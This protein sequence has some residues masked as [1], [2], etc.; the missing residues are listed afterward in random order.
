MPGAGGA[1][2]TET[3]PTSGDGSLS[4]H[5]HSVDQGSEGAGFLRGKSDQAGSRVGGVLA[6]VGAGNGRKRFGAGT[7]EPGSGNG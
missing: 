5:I 3:Q 6:A 2:V 7:S 1:R 4:A